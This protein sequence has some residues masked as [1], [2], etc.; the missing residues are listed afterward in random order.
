MILREATPEDLRPLAAFIKRRFDE[1]GYAAVT[2]EAHIKSWTSTGLRV[3]VLW[4]KGSIAAVLGAHPIETDEGKGSE[5]TLLLTSDD[6]PD[7][8]KALDA[9]CLYA[10][11]LGA[12]ERRHFV[13]SRDD[14]RHS[15][16]FYGR[17]Q[18]GMTAQ[19]QGRDTI[20]GKPA[21]LYNTGDVRTIA[22]AILRRR[23]EWR[24]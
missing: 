12:S 17:D 8:L 21:E 11:N 7:R 20:T 1:L 2:T 23:P 5:I 24:L 19:E 10:C 9:I 14:L 13:V 16:M 6:H 15:G 4:D 3:V 18:V 22:A